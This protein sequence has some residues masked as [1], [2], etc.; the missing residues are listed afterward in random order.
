MG[1]KEL[2]KSE[3]RKI[4]YNCR[5]ATF[6]IEKK[7]IGSITPFEKMK[8]KIHLAGCSVCR[9][10][11]KQSITI[12]RMVKELFSTSKHT[13]LKLDDG[14][15]KDMQERIERELNNE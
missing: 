9:I 11:E 2:N 5:E 12:N 4:A 10:F 13:E 6:L 15:K 1:M 14:F 8:L 3:L 7:Q